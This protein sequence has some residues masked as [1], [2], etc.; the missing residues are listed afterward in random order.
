MSLFWSGQLRLRHLSISLFFLAIDFIFNFIH[1]YLA[2][3]YPTCTHWLIT[4]N[5][6]DFT[7]KLEFF[8]W[9]VRAG[10]NAASTIVAIM[11]TSLS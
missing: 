6:R 1:R 7:L 4:V 9:L 8:G 10:I 11:P 2:F 5:R 3:A